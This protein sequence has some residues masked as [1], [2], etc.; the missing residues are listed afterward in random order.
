MAWH[1]LIEITFDPADYAGAD[2]PAKQ[3]A[4]IAFA[5]NFFGFYEG[6]TVAD[7]LDP[8]SPNTLAHPEVVFDG[9]DS[10]LRAE[11]TAEPVE[12]QGAFSDQALMNA[13]L[14]AAAGAKVNCFDPDPTKR[15]RYEKVGA[16]G[17][18]SWDLDGDIE[19]RLWLDGNHPGV[20]LFLTPFGSWIDADRSLTLA[21]SQMAYPAPPDDD[22]TRARFTVVIACEN[23]TLPRNAKWHL[24]MQGDIAARTAELPQVHGSG[25]FAM[26][27]YVHRDTLLSDALGFAQPGSWGTPNLVPTVEASG[28][29]TVV[30]EF[31]PD[32]LAWLCLGGKGRPL[33]DSPAVYV[34]APVSELLASLNGNIYWPIVAYGS[35]DDETPF[36]SATVADGDRPSGAVMLKSLKVEYWAD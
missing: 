23:L 3:A 7:V 22:W 5:K 4:V 31:T 8:S 11:F 27:N 35:P 12:V 24:H 10:H 6:G 17:A 14:D 32:D 2:T 34:A 25:N 21:G 16:P 13:D 33:A 15:G 26:P 30:V 9:A 28:W 19:D 1:D 20:A 18:G 29:K 36:A